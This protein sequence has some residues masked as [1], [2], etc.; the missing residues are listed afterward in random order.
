MALRLAQQKETH[1]HGTRVRSMRWSQA[2]SP[3]KSTSLRETGCQPR[4]SATAACTL[5]LLVVMAAEYCAS[6]QA[7]QGG[8]GRR[9][10]RSNN[11][12]GVRTGAARTSAEVESLVG[13][14]LWEMF[15]IYGR[16]K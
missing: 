16:R 6:H 1:D 8:C 14:K 10:Q 12:D 3:P 9:Q 4:S 7:R 5:A 15:G 13:L 11:A 2:L